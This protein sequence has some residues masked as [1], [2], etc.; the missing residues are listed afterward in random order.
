MNAATY[1][2]AI[3]IML[4]ALLAVATSASDLRAREPA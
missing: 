1:A 2:K 3:I 4:C